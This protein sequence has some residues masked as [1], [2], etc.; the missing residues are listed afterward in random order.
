M[1]TTLKTRKEQQMANPHPVPHWK[2]GISGN[3]KGRPKQEHS[4][5]QTIR[6]MMDEKPEIKRALGGKIFQLALA[7]DMVAIK[8]IWNYIDGMPPQ[9]PSVQI[10]NQ[11]EMEIQF[12]E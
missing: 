4:I 10:L 5:T 1:K 3:P 2:P 8:T 12:T 6:D 11:G 7:G 9:T